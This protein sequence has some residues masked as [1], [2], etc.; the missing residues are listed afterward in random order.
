MEVVEQMS[1]RP[2]RKRGPTQKNVRTAW[3]AVAIVLGLLV[4][5]R[6]GHA[7]LGGGSGVEVLNPGATSHASQTPSTTPGPAKGSVSAVFP[8]QVRGTRLE[9]KV[10]GLGN[11]PESCTPADLS[12]GND[13]R[14]VYHF[15]CKRLEAPASSAYFFLVKLTNRTNSTV[16]AE[17]SAFTVSTSDGGTLAALDATGATY[18]RPFTSTDLLPDASVKGWV[19]FDGSTPFTPSSL[20]YQDGGQT[21]TVGFRGAWA[22]T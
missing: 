19:T 3:I 8:D 9:L 18:Q 13:V 10:F 21:L 14:T 6:L 16:P 11:T 15:D 22:K 1:R 5:W 2:T 7:I 17:L 20:S 12:M 4:L